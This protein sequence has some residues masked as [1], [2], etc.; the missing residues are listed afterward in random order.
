MNQRI[1]STI[2]YIGSVAAATL[3]AALMN[4]NAFAEGPIDYP[5]TKF[6]GSLTR[7]EVR[8]QLMQD[9]SQ[10]TSAGSEWKLQQQPA[11]RAANGYTRQEARDEYIAARDEVHAMTAEDSGSNY[12]PRPRLHTPMNVFA[13]RGKR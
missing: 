1:T 9:R 7:A 3:A 13:V 10:L 12:V 5:S 8:A 4:N 6:V 11:L 2:G